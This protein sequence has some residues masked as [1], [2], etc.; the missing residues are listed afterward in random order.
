MSRHERPEPAAP[1]PAAPDPA[2][3]R[4]AV[5]RIV[6]MEVVSGLGDG[7][8]WVGFVALL[9]RLDVGAV[10]FGVAVAVRLGPRALLGV[11]GGAIADRLD[12][13][14]LLVALDLGRSAC[15]VALAVLADDGAGAA[16]PMTVVLVAYVLAAP[17]RP[18]LT[19]GLAAVAGESGLS[20]ANRAGSAPSGR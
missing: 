4:S 3:R 10:G 5:R 8:F 9:F 14:R 18:A 15:M 16:L 7:V 1:D 2:A 13:R 17:Y 6:T 19:A 20:T 11:P 12:R